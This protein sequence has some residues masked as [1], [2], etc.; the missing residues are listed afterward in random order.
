MSTRIQKHTHS[1]G[2][3]GSGRYVNV[4]INCSTR[5]S[6]N[7]KP[8][9][10]KSALKDLYYGITALTLLARRSKYPARNKPLQILT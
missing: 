6:K 1:D 10:D 7:I 4:C 2:G 3:G 9:P 5:C 8:T